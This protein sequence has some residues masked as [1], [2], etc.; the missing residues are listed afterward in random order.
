M[1]MIILIVTQRQL[2]IAFKILTAL[3]GTFL[4]SKEAFFA[5]KCS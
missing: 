4:N 1:T 2:Q 3:V 5:A